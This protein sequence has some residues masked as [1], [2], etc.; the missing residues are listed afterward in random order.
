MRNIFII[1]LTI[2]SVNSFAFGLVSKNNKAVESLN[3][4]LLY[5]AEN[6]LKE[7]LE[8]SPNNPILNYNY[9]L[10]KLRQFEEYKDQSALEDAI[11]GFEKAKADT[12]KTN[13]QAIH[14]NQANAYYNLKDYTRA[15][16]NYQ[17]AGTYLDSTNVDL[18]LIYNY[19]NSIYKFVEENTQH[20]SLLT[21]VEQMYKSSL[22]GGDNQLKEKV[23]HNLGNTAFQQ[24][25]YQDALAYYIEA[26]KLNPQ[27]ENT[28]INYEIALRKLD[29]QK[30]QN[31]Q[32]DKSEEGN[33][34]QEQDESTSQEQEQQ[35]QD[36]Q[37]K[38]EQYDDLTQEEKEKLEAEK[39]LDALL[40]EQSRDDDNEEK[41]KI[42]QQRPTGRYW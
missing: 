42:R 5:N 7:G 4:T 34:Q 6:Q 10:T 15:L 22:S 30:G 26:L 36:A 39:K 14:Y 18:D 11:E 31:Q 13:L 16:Q 21:M 17:E 19:A 8:K 40:Q 35:K 23:F 9:G 28:R 32:Q 38:Q 41:K 29:Q 20:D 25:K 33:S 3:D 37:D 2:I 24:E 1:I 27:S 12:S